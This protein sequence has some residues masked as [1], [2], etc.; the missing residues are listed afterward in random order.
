MAWAMVAGAAVSVAGGMISGSKAKKAQ[1]AQ[2]AYR[3]QQGIGAAEAYDNLGRSYLASINKP[4][5]YNNGVASS[6]INPVTGEAGFTL[7]PQWQGAY[8]GMMTGGQKSLDLAGSFDPKAHAAERFGAAQALLA[9][10]D[11]QAEASLMQELYNKGGFGL[12]TNT[13]AVG[14]GDVS[15]NPY[16]STFLNARNTRNAGMAYKSLGEGESYLDNLLS[17]S[18]GM[19]GQAL[20]INRMGEGSM[21]GNMNM[22]GMF[23]REMT[24]YMEMLSKGNAARFG[25]QQDPGFGAN[26]ESQQWAAGA[27]RVGGMVGKIDW[28][29]LNNSGYSPN[30][31]AMPG[32]YFGGS[33]STWAPGVG[34]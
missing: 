30:T 33:S 5:D 25:I 18:K 15:V 9:P 19:F 21:T 3:H 13:Q 24:P 17:R 23:G 20:D 4:S 26:N 2:D 22:R 31:V 8:N 11:A 7:A 6:H 32:S 27:D 16:T 10:G 29:K 28:S 14:G 34:F 12:R 1:A